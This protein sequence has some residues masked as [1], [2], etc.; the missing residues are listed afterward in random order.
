MSA[1]SLFLAVCSFIHHN[2]WSLII[3]CYP[4]IN[5]NTTPT[6][7]TNQLYRNSPKTTSSWAN[8][9]TS[10]PKSTP[11]PA[12]DQPTKSSPPPAARTLKHGKNQS[13]PSS[14]HSKDHATSPQ[15]YYPN[16]NKSMD[17]MPLLKI[18]NYHP[19]RSPSG[20]GMG[21]KKTRGWI[22]MSS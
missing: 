5:Q 4:K 10:S 15:D 20:R 9:S 11:T 13:K 22:W 3:L 12:S 17:G 6:T 1:H 8:H 19:M 7:H 14:A 21:P 16:S 18:I 2:R